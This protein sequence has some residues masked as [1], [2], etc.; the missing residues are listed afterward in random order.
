MRIFLKEI[1]MLVFLQEKLRN[2]KNKKKKKQSERKKP[3]QI[4]QQK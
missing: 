1:Q 2:R 3:K 4:E